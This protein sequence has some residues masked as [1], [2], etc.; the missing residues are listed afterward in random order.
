MESRVKFR[1]GSD[2][3]F[4]LLHQNEKKIT[5]SWNLRVTKFLSKCHLESCLDSWVASPIDF[6]LKLGALHV[7]DYE[8]LS[9]ACFLIKW[10]EDGSWDPVSPHT[11]CQSWL[12]LILRSNIPFSPARAGILFL[13]IQSVLCRKTY[14]LSQTN[15]TNKNFCPSLH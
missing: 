10:W 8:I 12:L 2:P 7:A 6:R 11:L 5:Y 3:Q 15:K 14:K 1:R 4:R 13:Q 9:Q